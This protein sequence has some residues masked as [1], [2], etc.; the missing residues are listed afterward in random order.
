MIRYALAYCRVSDT[1]QRTEGH[2]LESQQHR[3]IQFAE[4]KGL[5]IEKIFHD[6]VTAGGNFNKRP[7]MNQIL[8]YLAANQDKKYVVIFDDIKRFSRDVY[9]YWDLIKKLDVYGADPMSPNFV[10]E[11]TPEGRFQQSI[12]VAAGEYERESIARQTKQKTKARLEAGF[13]AFIA[14]AGFKYEK[15]KGRGK[16]LVKDEPTASVI[17]EMMEGFASGRFQTKRECK[18]FLEAAPEFPK[19]ASGRIGNNQVDKMLTNPLYAGMIEYKPWGI[20]L[21]QGN[22]EGMVTYQTFLKIQER[23]LG[24]KHAPA[25]KD[26]NKDFPL[27]GAVSCECG[28]ALTAAWSKSKSGKLHPYYVCQN[29]KCTYKGKSIRR[30]VLEGEFEKLLKSLKPSRNVLSLASAM[31]KDLW[32]HMAK[33]QQQRKANFIK[34]QHKLDQEINKMLERLI[35]TDSATVRKAFEDKIEKLEKQK[36]VLTEKI[37]NTGKPQRP[38]EQMYRT[39]I[40]FLSNPYKVWANGGFQGKRAVLKLTFPNRLIWDRLGM[41]RTPQISDVFRVFENFKQNLKMVPRRGLEPPRP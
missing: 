2:G 26:L 35:E 8:N 27:R 16:T 10:F 6:D 9:F 36:L 1:K 38:F 31:F 17:A 12:T 4:E 28:N 11:K 30:D 34:N 29:R 21:R 39:P 23:L 5:I 19:T 40:E 3:C 13:H 37:A 41:Y 14:P 32:D 7:A 20:T 24:R 25:R 22:H 15:V 33:T 18:Y